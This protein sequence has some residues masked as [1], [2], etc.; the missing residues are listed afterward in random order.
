MTLETQLRDALAARADDIDGP[1][2]DPYERVSGA[3]AA[4]R[5]RRRTAAVGAV[6]AVAALAVLV[7]S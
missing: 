7:P 6:A 3:V 5:R 4:S 2:A 1:A